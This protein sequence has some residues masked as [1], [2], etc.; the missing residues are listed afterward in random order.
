MYSHQTGGNGKNFP[1][2]VKA[3]NQSKKD[4]FIALP[5]EVYMIAMTAQ[6]EKTTF[7]KKDVNFVGGLK[8]DFAIG[9]YEASCFFYIYFSFG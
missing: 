2:M 4:N 8:L 5:I 9:I 6:K 3:N 1:N 7:H